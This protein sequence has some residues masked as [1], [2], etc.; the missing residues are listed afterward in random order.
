M[1]DLT[2]LRPWN[3][4]LLYHYNTLKIRDPRGR[5]HVEHE[6]WKKSMT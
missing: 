3:L 5:F 4:Y 6:Q 2:L 1:I